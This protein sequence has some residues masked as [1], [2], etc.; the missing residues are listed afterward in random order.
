MHFG[1]ALWYIKINLIYSQVISFAIWKSESLRNIQIIQIKAKFYRIK[2]ES[3]KYFFQIE[4][5]IDLLSN[6]LRR[7]YIFSVEFDGIY[8]GINNLKKFQLS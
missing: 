2:H 7:F 4:K 8:Y 1:N 6:T 3:N 5:S